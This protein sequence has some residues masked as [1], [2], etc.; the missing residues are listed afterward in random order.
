MDFD[1]VEFDGDFDGVGG[2]G[3]EDDYSWSFSTIPIPPKVI[4]VVPRNLATMVEAEKPIE[5]RFSKPMDQF[6]VLWALKYHDG[7]FNWTYASILDNFTWETDSKLL[8][9]PSSGWEHD[10]EYTVMIEASAMDTQGV[11]LD[12]D[13]DGLPEG[14]GID[15][16]SWSFTTI[17][18]APEV[19]SVE[20][21]DN[22]D[23][24]AVDADIVIVFNRAMNKDATEDAFS[25]TDE[26]GVNVF[27][28]RDGEPTWTNGDTRLTF[29][30]D[31]DFEEGMTYIVTI[32]ETAEDIDGV[33]FDGFEWEF[34]TKV[35]SPPVLKQGGVYP[36]TGDTETLF[37]FTV[38][39]SDED[40]DEPK[41]VRAVV[42][43][44]SLKMRES[45]TTTKNF[46]EGKVYE[47][48]IKLDSG[49]HTY[50]Y[51]SSNE[52]HDVRFPTG[53]ATKKLKVKEQEKEL[54]FGI[55]EEEIAGMP[56]M[57][58]LPLGIIILVVIIISV[59]MVIRRGRGARTPEPGAQTMT[60]E[61]FEAASEDEA[62]MTFMP[63][64]EEELM[65]FTSFEE[66]KPVVIQCPECNSFLKVSAETRPFMF[67]CK[68]GAKL[69]LK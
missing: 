15:D 24:V 4:S 62:T 60:F 43:G 46:T 59:I 56:T 40:G 48:E 26:D 22:E 33:E 63:T 3:P 58:C 37:K 65:T 66:E 27:E 23:E 6:S 35:N 49:E 13:R 8:Y 11:T 17:K 16:Y 29:N 41:T 47:L 1:E 67:P 45:D 32:D 7:S 69:I 50:Y 53:D 64:D 20:P 44:Q 52:K 38:V 2:E 55:F 28:I 68:C 18:E 34:T 57:T 36:E 31:I 51:V 9:E 5:I 61:T 10:T 21:D 30:P 14:E 39:Y 25:F 19:E 54:V 42:D 12:G